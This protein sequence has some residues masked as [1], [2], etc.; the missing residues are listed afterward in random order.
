MLLNAQHSKKKF[1]K[2]GSKKSIYKKKKINKL[3]KLIIKF[4]CLHWKI[5]YFKKYFYIMINVCG[6]L[7]VLKANFLR[8]SDK[9][10]K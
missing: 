9:K 6:V 3:S 5:K 4:K 7:N 2:N 8:K 1:P 10:W